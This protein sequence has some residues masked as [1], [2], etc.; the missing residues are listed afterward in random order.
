MYM[1]DIL[2]IP[3]NLSGLPALSVPCGQ[4]DKGLP[5]GVQFIGP[6]FTEA[7]LLSLGQFVEENVY[8][9]KVDHGF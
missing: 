2:T 4:D 9:E 6:A 8:Q 7:R 3:V 1:N 5:I